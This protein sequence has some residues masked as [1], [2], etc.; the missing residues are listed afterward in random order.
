MRQT[1]GCALGNL[2]SLVIATTAT[3]PT[4]MRLS[5]YNT[6]EKCNRDCFDP[7]YEL[8][9]GERATS[10]MDWEVSLRPRAKGEKRGQRPGPFV[11]SLL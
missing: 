8:E 2:C 5:R 11:A 10:I 7:C 3:L 4:V 1:K 6:D 9:D